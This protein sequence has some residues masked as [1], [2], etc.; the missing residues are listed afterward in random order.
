MSKHCKCTFDNIISSKEI[1]S[2]SDLEQKCKFHKRILLTTED[3]FVCQ[4]TFKIKL[5]CP[6][7]EQK[8]LKLGDFLKNPHKCCPPCS[9]RRKSYWEIFDEMTN[10]GC[11]ISIQEK[12]FISKKESF[13]FICSCGKD[14]KTSYFVWKK[15]PKCKYCGSYYVKNFE[16]VRT[17]CQEK[18]INLTSTKDGFDWKNIQWLCSD[19]DVEQISTFSQLKI[20]KYPTCTSCSSKRGNINKVTPEDFYLSMSKEDYSMKS[21]RHEFKNNKSIMGAK[22]PFGHHFYTNWDRWQ[23][24]HRCRE[25]FNESLRKKD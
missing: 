10:A 6:R 3:E 4:K 25:C 7:Y 16:E 1:K 11:Q 23:R 8:E 20:K 14:R 18:E 2:F 22:C 13:E 17:L 9:K 24:G 19:C 15:T 21:D 12:H 5:F